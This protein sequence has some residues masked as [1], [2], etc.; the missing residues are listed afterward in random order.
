[1][2][3]LVLTKGE[4]DA[5]SYN[6]KKNPA[7]KFAGAATNFKLPEIRPPNLWVYGHACGMKNRF[8]DSSKTAE[9]L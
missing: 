4:G 6:F 3:A 2:R 7:E 1:L 5:C 8:V 9:N